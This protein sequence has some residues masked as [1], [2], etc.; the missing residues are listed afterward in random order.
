MMSERGISKSYDTF[1]ILLDHWCAMNTFGAFLATIEDMR[2]AGFAPQIHVVQA[3]MHK[4]ERVRL[5]KL[6]HFSTVGSRHVA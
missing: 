4:A 2:E 3:A 1:V 5:C 6:Y